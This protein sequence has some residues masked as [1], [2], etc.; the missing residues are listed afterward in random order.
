[1]SEIERHI[2]Y[3]IPSMWNLKYGTNDPIYKTEKDHGHGEPT[4]GC[5]GEGRK[6]WDGRVVWSLMPNSYIWN[7]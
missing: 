1:M 5:Q 4:C 3:D 2:P 7:E 6:E